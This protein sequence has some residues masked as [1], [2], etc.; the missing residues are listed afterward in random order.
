[1][2]HSIHTC[3][4]LPYIPAHFPGEL[5]S[6]WLRRIG[7]E[8]G[9]SLE[10]LAQH[11]GLSRSKSIEID[12]DLTANDI[13]RLAGALRW[14]PREL[15]QAMHHPLRPHVRALRAARSPI[16]LCSG[17][18][19]HHLAANAKAVLIKSWFE[20]WQI[21]CR[22]CS[23]PLLSVGGPVMN[24]CNPARDEPVWFAR[25]LPAARAG[26]ARLHSFARRPF[27]T[28]LSPVAVLCLLSKVL[29]PV[30]TQP[31]DAKLDDDALLGSGYVA[32]LFVPGLRQLVRDEALV[33]TPW[34]ESKP[35][36]PVA[37]RII[38][39]AALSNFL[40]DPRQSCR[41]VRDVGGFSARSSLE[42]W[43]TGLPLHSREFLA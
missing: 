15:R 28:S 29:R 10:R 41:T 2:M 19:T 8:Y 43:F 34:T 38:L 3:P 6:S 23:I 31:D 25:I 42:R 21:E 11:F 7:T 20:Y 37:P 35:V 18:R 16:Q 1:M 22:V 40:R 13:Q 24:H 33:L 39:L 5:L 30:W 36:R 9:V 4:P 17:C 32:E 12:H 26:A 27:N 14:S